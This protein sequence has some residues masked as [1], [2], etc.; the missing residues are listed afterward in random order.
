MRRF[1][2]HLF[3]RQELLRLYVWLGRIGTRKKG[4]LG[5]RNLFIR[6]SNI[7]VLGLVRKYKGFRFTWGILIKGFWETGNNRSAK[8][9][10]SSFFA[11]SLTVSVLLFNVI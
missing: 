1:P 9:P 6:T 5:S 4:S 7:R 2:S 8:G 3:I 10:S 11:Q